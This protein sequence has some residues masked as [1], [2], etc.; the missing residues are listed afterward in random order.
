VASHERSTFLKRLETTSCEDA[1]ADQ[2]R[3][4]FDINSTGYTIRSKTS[5]L[6]FEIDVDI[7]FNH[8]IQILGPKFE[9]KLVEFSQ[10][11]TQ[12]AKN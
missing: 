6:N 1:A 5:N 11:L 2:A 3:T 9:K 7:I 4:N 8:K 12:I 10:I